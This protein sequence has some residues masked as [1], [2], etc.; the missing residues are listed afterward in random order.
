[1]MMALEEWVVVE[2]GKRVGWHTS[3]PN[4]DRL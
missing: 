1:M 4:L 2:E 3:C